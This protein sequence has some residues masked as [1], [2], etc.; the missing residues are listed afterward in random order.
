M[1]TLFLAISRRLGLPQ[2][3]APLTRSVPALTSGHFHP[4]RV[5]LPRPEVLAQVDV[6][7]LLGP[8]GPQWDSPP[9]PQV[10]P[11]P[12][13]PHE[14]VFWT[15]MH[16]PWSLPTLPIEF[17]FVNSERFYYVATLGNCSCH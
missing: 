14:D 2:P 15:H 12:N 1:A 5:Y 17:Q 16:T 3:P 11:A 6:D 9:L 8:L 10:I 13:F 4:E 7:G